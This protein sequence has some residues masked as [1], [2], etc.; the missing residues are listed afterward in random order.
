[1]ADDQWN[2]VKELKAKYPGLQSWSDDAVLENML[3]TNKFRSA[4]P[5]YAGL[6]DNKIKT[7]ISKLL[8]KQPGYL[9][10]NRPDKTGKG[11]GLYKMQGP[12]AQIIQVPYDKVPVALAT[13]EWGWT[14]VG[15]KNPDEQ[16]SSGDQY[17]KDKEAEGKE[18][19]LTGRA[20]EAMQRA[21][22]PTPGFKGTL[23]TPIP[24]IDVNAAKAAGRVLYTSPEFVKDLAYAFYKASAPGGGAQ[25]V[26][27]VFEMV[28]PFNVPEQL[29]KQFHEDVQKDPRMAVDNLI[30]NLAG[31]GIVG[32]ITH[33]AEQVIPK[34]AGR[35]IDVVKNIPRATLEAVTET[36]PRDVRTMAEDTEEKNEAARQKSV[37][38]YETAHKGY[39][40]KKAE[41]EE[42]TTGVEVGHKYDVHQEA[43]K[44]VADYR[45]AAQEN[46]EHN[47]RVWLKTAE[48]HRKASEGVREDNG[49]VNAKYA[50]EKQ[51]IEDKNKAA[52]HVLELR[53]STEADLA[54]KTQQY[55]T[56]EGVVKNDAK[57]LENT[58]WDDWRTKT[59]ASVGDVDMAPVLKVIEEQITKIPEAANILKNVEVQDGALDPDTQ[60]YLDVRSQVMKSLN[61]G[62]DYEGLSPA[63]QEDV[64]ALV[65]RKITRTTPTANL[66]EVK[67][68]TLEQIHAIKSN[69]GFKRFNRTYPPDV[70]YAMSDIY[71]A[72]SDLEQEESIRRGGGK[73]LSNAKDFTQKYQKAFGRKPY[74]PI[75]ESD[76]RER[77]ANP[78]AY[79]ER[80]EAKRLENA[81]VWSQKLVQSYQAVKD[82]REALKK[83]PDEDELRESLKQVPLPPTVGDLRF[84]YALKEEPVYDPPTVGDLR[85]GYAL[86]PPVQPPE[87]GAAYQA[88][89]EP[90]RVPLPE[91]PQYEAPEP[92]T[93]SPED[94]EKNKRGHIKVQARELRRMGLRR[95]LYATL[96]GIPFAIH[97][98]FIHSAAEGEVA[99]IGGI[100]AGGAVLAFSHMIANLVERP[101]VASW[102]SQ[103]TDKD[104][105]VWEKLPE[106][107]KAL[108]TDDMKALVRVADE[109]HIPV[110][111]YLRIFVTA[112]VAGSQKNTPDELKKK[113]E[114]HWQQIQAPT[115]SPTEGGSSPQPALSNPEPTPNA[116]A[117]TVG[118][119]SSATPSYTHI[120]DPESGTIMQVQ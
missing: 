104:V 86:K 57:K 101:D 66:T 116:G 67:T 16:V 48:A 94:I 89:K 112:G 91:E 63:K 21:L 107:Q 120:Y 75:T 29:Q 100:A 96:T 40:T 49:K 33:G 76:L 99:T 74:E 46:H 37:E 114:Q 110:S 72:L 90:L 43:G 17:A 62:D 102:L 12:N 28:N 22:Q 38:D 13:G 117:Y 105:A 81:R 35:G 69:I 15:G 55:F 10:T 71:D 79:K 5:Q 3:D 93:I 95:A 106:N 44:Q 36:S 65:S 31:L 23:P 98:A 50:E 60:K 41:A 108:F 20:N 56:E 6:D 88:V 34:V 39:E 80:K 25:E 7:N 52:E 1:M 26:N 11:Q 109:K 73:E 92:E 19:S 45:K 78:D 53:R 77:E 83:F 70:R 97:A 32:G 87:A 68:M 30:G 47:A 61:Y 24:G 42:E 27:N 113:A 118:P 115:P 103:V 2:P 119:Q 64:D 8:A 58:A 84:G 111:P 85:S 18:P 59:N 4:F 14:N 82:T 54:Q 51:R 9:S